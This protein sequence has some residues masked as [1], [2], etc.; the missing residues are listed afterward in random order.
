M[1]IGYML[2]SKMKNSNLE[3]NAAVLLN[4][5]EEQISTREAPVRIRDIPH[6][7]RTKLSAGLVEP[8]FPQQGDG[9]IDAP[10]LFLC[11]ALDSLARRIDASRTPARKQTAS[12]IIAS[13]RKLPDEIY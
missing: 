11:T 6:A 12:S 9:Y 4:A 8:H 2:S 10:I 1:I 3:D 7:L 5:L 13:I